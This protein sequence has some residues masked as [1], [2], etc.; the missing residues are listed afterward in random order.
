MGEKLRDALCGASYIAASVQGL[1][2]RQD[3]QS[4]GNL[5]T[6]PRDRRRGI[7]LLDP[8]SSRACGDVQTCPVALLSFASIGTGAR[9]NPAQRDLLVEGMGW[10]VE[11]RA[12]HR[13]I[14]RGEAHE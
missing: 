11:G 9:R 6:A 8:P 1:L 3:I 7:M 14:T 12:D 4:M 2:K 13:I 5:T 10:S